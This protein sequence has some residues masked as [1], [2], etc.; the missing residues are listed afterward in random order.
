MAKT[1]RTDLGLS[2]HPATYVL[3]VPQAEKAGQVFAAGAVLQLSSGYLIG[4]AT[5]TL[6][7]GYGIAIDSGQDLAADGDA[8]ASIYRFEQGAMYEGTLNGVLAQANIGTTAKLAQASG[9][10][11]TFTVETGGTQKWRIVGPAPGWEVGDTN[12][13]I[14]AIPFDSFIEQ[15]GGNE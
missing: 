13:R 7:T 10:I 15:G 8:K 12:A 9:G 14:Y 3:N 11:P 1:G 5:G 2:P 6:S 4:S